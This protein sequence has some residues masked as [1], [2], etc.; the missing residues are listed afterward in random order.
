MNDHIILSEYQWSAISEFIRNLAKIADIES[1]IDS[2]T[3]NEIFQYVLEL[4][5][6]NILLEL[7]K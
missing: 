6:K 5:R 4:E 3:L 1:N 2:K 7:R